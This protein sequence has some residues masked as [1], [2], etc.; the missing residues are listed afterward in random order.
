M[1]IS[2]ALLDKIFEDGCGLVSHK[3]IQVLVTRCLLSKANHCNWFFMLQCRMLHIRRCLQLVG[4]DLTFC[5]VYLSSL[6]STSIKP[7]ETYI[8]SFSSSACSI[9]LIRYKKVYIV[10]AFIGFAYTK[11][12]QPQKVEMKAYLAIGSSRIFLDRRQE[13]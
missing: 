13:I 6:S 5:L 12:M 1:S 4:S 10:S 7:I 2:T 11:G 3:A 8:N 9:I